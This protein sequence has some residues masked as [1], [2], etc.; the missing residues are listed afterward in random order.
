MKVPGIDVIFSTDGTAVLSNNVRVSARMGPLPMV[1]QRDD[2]TQVLIVSNVPTTTNFYGLGRLD[3]TFL[4]DTPITWTGTIDPL[5]ACNTS[6]PTPDPACVPADSAMQADITAALIPVQAAASDVVGSSNVQLTSTCRTGECTGMMAVADAIMWGMGD[7]CDAVFLNGGSATNPMGPG[8]ITVG[9]VDLFMPF[10]NYVA[11]AGMRG[12]D[13]IDM[14]INGLSRSNPLTDNSKGTGRFPQIAALRIRYN[15]NVTIPHRVFSVEWKNRATGLYEPIQ[16]DKV[17]QLCTNDYMRA[18]GDD[19]TMLATNALNAFDKGPQ[20]DVMFKQYLEKFSPLPAPVGGRIILAD[21]STT[22]GDQ[23]FFIGNCNYLL[24]NSNASGILNDTCGGG[25]IGSQV[26]RY[27]HSNSVVLGTRY[28]TNITF[29]IAPSTPARAIYLSFANSDLV[30]DPTTDLLTLTSTAGPILVK[31]DT[32]LTWVPANYTTMPLMIQVANYPNLQVHL[33][34]RRAITGTGLS[35]A[36]TTNS[37]CPPGYSLSVAE[38]ACVPCNVG[39]TSL[40]GDVKC[41]ACPAGTSGIGFASEMCV[42]CKN[43][44]YTDGP[45]MQSCLPC[46]SG[47]IWTSPKRCDC[48]GDSWWNG[49]VCMPLDKSKSEAGQVAAISITLAVVVGAAGFYTYRRRMALI[50][51]R[52]M[53]IHKHKELKTDLVMTH[54]INGIIASFIFIALEGADCGLDWLAFVH[55]HG[56]SRFRLAYVAGCIFGSCVTFLSILI[57]LYNAYTLNSFRTKG[58]TLIAAGSNVSSQEAVDRIAHAASDKELQK[59]IL[60]LNTARQEMIITL[61]V[62]I[63]GLV[64]AVPMMVVNVL[65]GTQQNLDA[66]LYAAF[67]FNVLLFTNHAKDAIHWPTL[68][69]RYNLVKVRVDQLLADRGLARPE[70]A[71]V[72]T[73]APPETPLEKAI[74]GMGSMTLSRKD[75]NL[76]E[77]QPGIVKSAVVG[78]QDVSSGR[79][80]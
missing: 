74:K 76:E 15:K 70:R 38:S 56:G 41:T 69:N 5:L 24:S 4:N 77:G 32:N 53:G 63:P 19:Y 25:N 23:G 51:R 79:K 55:V 30:L 37:N 21:A 46:D 26:I 57:R 58:I 60:E 72:R 35:I 9:A 1:V 14:F 47:R 29:N 62:A 48:P 16:A 39:M 33:T 8:N 42:E 59:A 20:L 52:Q 2:G 49:F 54:L 80:R 68:R 28:A 50:K 43:G 31:S 36:Y 34:S 66:A 67:G 27:R 40:P 18:G 13:I 78:S 6:S 22:S 7:T 61:C 45:G 44:T 17:Y 12:A 11:I 64:K 71:N 73:A 10:K 75:F 65:V 3:L